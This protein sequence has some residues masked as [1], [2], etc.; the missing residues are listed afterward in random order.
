MGIANSDF[1][2]S[3]MVLVSV[4]KRNHKRS[5]IAQQIAASEKSTL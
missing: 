4:Y 5:L 2:S 3:T 1:A